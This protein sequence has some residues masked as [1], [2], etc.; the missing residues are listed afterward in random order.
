MY[1]C[2]KNSIKSY[3][4]KEK[5]K[6]LEFILKFVDGLSKNQF[7]LVKLIVDKAAIGLVVTIVGV[8]F[9][10]LLEKYKSSLLKKLEMSKFHIPRVA[11]LLEQA[12]S[13]HKLGMS[14]ILELFEE[15]KLYVEWEK[16]IIKS[17]QQLTDVQILPLDPSAKN[18]VINPKDK[19]PMTLFRLLYGSTNNPR[20][21]RL[22]REDEFWENERLYDIGEGLI[23]RL[24]SEINFNSKFLFKD[25]VMNLFIENSKELRKEYNDQVN[26][27][28]HKIMINLYAE[29]RK[30]KRVANII[31]KSLSLCSDAVNDFPKNDVYKAIEQDVS[32]ITVF[33]MSYAALLSNIK[34]Y[35][36]IIENA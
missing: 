16:E 9:Y 6:K 33:T 20:I 15:Y 12:E 5:D 1:Q 7:E 22:L 32:A 18:F 36:K 24:N 10:F 19:E 4:L 29:S 23:A 13:M 25:A 31:K 8:I 14:V 30:Q 11:A 21:L 27:Y 2:C 35:I 26:D 34:R 3:S 17:V 28:R